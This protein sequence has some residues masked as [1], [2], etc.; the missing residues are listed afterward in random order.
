MN[1]R[2]LAVAVAAAVAIGGSALPSAAV[3]VAPEP[4]VEITAVDTTG[5]PTVTATV[6]APGITPYPADSFRAFEGGDPVA[7][8]VTRLPTEGLEVMLVIDVSESMGS[9]RRLSTA[10]D[11]VGDFLDLIPPEVGVGAIAYS[12]EPDLL[13]APTLDRDAVVD[14]VATLA[15]LD[16]TATYDAIVVAV[17]GFSSDADHRAI[18][19][20]TDGED[21]ASSATLDDAVASASDVPVHVIALEPSPEDLV[22]LDRIA[23]AGGGSIAVAEDAAALQGVY[24]DAVDTLANRYFVTYESTGRGATDLRIVLTTLDSE[25]TVPLQLPLPATTTSAS[26]ST[27]SST[28]STTTSTTVAPATTVASPVMPA[29]STIP[30]TSVEPGAAVNGDDDAGELRLLIGGVAIFLA[31]LIVA[32]IL[33][34]DDSRRRTRIRTGLGLDRL[35]P[36]SQRLAIT[37]SMATRAEQYLERSGRSRSIAGALEAA[38]ISL[39]PGEL[40]VLVLAVTAVA[41]LGGFVLAGPLV[42][43][44]ALATVPL[45]ARV[46]LDRAAARRREAF[47][48]QLADNIQLLTSSLKAGHGLLAALDNVANEAPEP[49]RGEF[50]RVLLEV[51]VGRDLTDALTALAHRMASIDFEWV[52][53]AIDINRE[54]GG[55][56]AET[57]DNV[58]ETIRERGR[59]ARHVHALTAEGRLSAY[60]LTG[61]PFFLAVMMSLVNPGYLDPLFAGGGLV[62]VGLSA[63]LLVVGWVWMKRLIRIDF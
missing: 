1:V 48:E 21:T 50:R 32:G 33:L 28:T 17:E 6:T 11:A 41:A 25:D 40:I 43:V 42:A 54:I 3:A 62:A 61:L 10:V 52:V 29:P 36:S 26:T 31:L 27:T 56:L 18:L 8:D 38:G 44:V 58:A 46:V 39:R 53:G 24:R 20:L 9:E 19:L 63:G 4:G 14:E 34:T 60:I 7:A 2:R 16:E 47:S 23:T 51:R 15:P 30:A 22:E 59:V 49:S 55:D 5:Y 37:E 35:R 45:V 13:I 57:L 12:D